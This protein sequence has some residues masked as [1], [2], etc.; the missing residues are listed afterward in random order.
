MMSVTTCVYST[1]GHCMKDTEGGDV[2]M[3]CR[4]AYRIVNGDKKDRR[5]ERKTQREQSKVLGAS[6]LG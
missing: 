4:V 2:G 6:L 3:W 1:H 5:A